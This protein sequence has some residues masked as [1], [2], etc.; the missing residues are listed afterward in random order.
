MS[1]VS[2]YNVPSQAWQILWE[3]APPLENAYW[4]YQSA[5]IRNKYNSLKNEGGPAAHNERFMDNIDNPAARAKV[6]GELDKYFPNGPESGWGVLGS[7]LI[8]AGKLQEYSTPEKKE[9]YESYKSEL[10]NTCLRWIKSG[11]LV[12]VGYS[13]DRRP[14]DKVSKV[15][16]DLIAN[17]Y[18]NWNDNKISYSSLDMV[19]I[20]IIH[21]EKIEEI[22]QDIHEQTNKTHGRTE[23]KKQIITKPDLPNPALGRPTKEDLILR[24][25]KLGVENDAIDFTQSNK[26]IYSTVESIICNEWPEEYEAGKGLGITPMRKYLMDEIKRNKL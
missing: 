8:G 26:I 11:K 4:Y 9:E 18:Y 1:S 24:A 20:R 25:F 13:K 21:P 23:D 17:G 16:T 19:D 14:Q 22:M 15:P 12:A 5:E 2:Y 10:E 3:N 6:K 7:F